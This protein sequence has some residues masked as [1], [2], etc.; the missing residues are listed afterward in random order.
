M[1]DTVCAV[2]EC[3]ANPA[4]KHAYSVFVVVPDPCEA[5]GC[6]LADEIDPPSQFVTMIEVV[7][8]EG[9]NAVVADVVVVHA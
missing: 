4:G 2:L 7:A 8:L 9:G 1:I 6:L 5:D 3:L